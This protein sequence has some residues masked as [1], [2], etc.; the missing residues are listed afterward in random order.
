MKK[1]TIVTGGAGF[2]GSHLVDKLIKKGRKVIVIDNLV[3]G[4]IDNLNLK[5]RFIEEDISTISLSEVMRLTQ[6]VEEIYHLASIASPPTYQENPIMTIMANTKGTHK[7]LQ[8][9][10]VFG[11]KVLFAST[12]EIYGDPTEHPQKETYFGNVNPFGPR[13][14]YDE[15][16]RLGETYCY[17]AKQ[18][19]VK[20]QIARIFNTY[21]P[22]MDKNDGRVI[23]NFIEAGRNNET[24][25]IHG[26]EQTRSFCYVDD[27]VDGLMR[28]MKKGDGNPYN[29]GNPREIKIDRLSFLVAQA[30]DKDIM[31]KIVEYREDDPMK[32][33]PDITRIKKL[34]WKPKIDIE[35]GLIKMLKE[36]K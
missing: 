5:V 20:V 2:L 9:A 36:G 24:T 7:M 19:G 18:I 13:S 1:Y 3:T 32:R 26:G 21:G 27:T 30:M 12:S 14:C 35:E 11:A 34:G 10:E 25:I 28:I 4:N 29:V 22:R 17:L 31:F 8:W 23:T 16:K 6:N 15:S 33:K